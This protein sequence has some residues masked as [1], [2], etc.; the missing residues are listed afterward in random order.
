MNRFH[1]LLQLKFNAFLNTGRRMHSRSRMEFAT[2]LLFLIG[3]AACFF[4]FFL[5]SFRFFSKQEPF[6]PI[7]IDESLYL[8]NFSIFIMFLISSGVSAF[9]SLFRSNEI[10]FLLSKPVEWTEIYFLKLLE[11]MWQSS[12][13]FALIAAPFI[14]VYGVTKS[15]GS[16]FFS[17]A[18]LAFYILFVFLSCTLGTLSAVITVWLLP[19]KRRRWVALAIL[20]LGI[21]AFLARV[22]PQ[23]IKEQGSIA[24]ILSGYLPHIGFAKNA[25]L[26]STWVTQGIQAFS[27]LKAGSWALKEGGFYFLLLLANALF[28][29]IPSYS[30]AGRLFPAAFLKSQDHGEVRAPQQARGTRFLEKFFDLLQIGRASCRER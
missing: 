23:V 19:S 1:L 17:F 21:S 5:Q 24:G 13:T 2:L 20:A 22:Q 27:A 11:A 28:F 29:I 12:W 26:P 4:S 8:F 10:P 18:C 14:A 30:A 16:I 7:L 3:V 6:G 15:T 25:F 9:A